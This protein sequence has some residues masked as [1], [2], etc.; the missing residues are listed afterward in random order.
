MHSQ[1]QKVHKN[2]ISTF[3]VGFHEHQ[4]GYKDNVDNV[5]YLS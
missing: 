3:L 4:G 1:T 2:M 5:V